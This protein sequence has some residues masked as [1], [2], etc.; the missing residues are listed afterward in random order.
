[1]GGEGRIAATEREK[2]SERDSRSGNAGLKQ[3]TI[4]ANAEFRGR[5]LEFVRAA[6]SVELKERDGVAATVRCERPSFLVEERVFF[7]FLSIKHLKSLS[8]FNIN[9]N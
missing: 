2:E 5:V 8:L 3:P 4:S 1:M 7:I 6:G 9:L